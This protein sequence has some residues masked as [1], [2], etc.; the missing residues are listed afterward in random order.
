METGN[1]NV[2]KR[3]SEL[4]NEINILIDSLTKKKSILTE[5]L[6]E[7]QRQLEMVSLDS[8]NLEDFDVLVDRKSDLLEKNNLNDEGFDSIFQRIRN[9]LVAQK[10]QYATEI[11]LMQELIR[12][13]LDLGSDIHNIEQQIKN[14][15]DA[16]LRENKSRLT[17]EKLG[18]KAVMD[19]Y[20]QANQMD[21]VS[22]AFLDQKK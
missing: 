6:E 2:R 15:L 22:P 18:G 8:F 10:V 3:K 20:K 11:A 4:K 17:K 9:E 16:A 5:I 14:G 7:S 19:Y 12:A 13:N 1:G 21:Y